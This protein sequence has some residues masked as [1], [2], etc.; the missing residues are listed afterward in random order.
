M[1]PNEKIGVT[2]NGQYMPEGDWQKEVEWIRVS[3]DT[4]NEKTFK[5]IKDGSLEKSL[6]TLKQLIQGSI[7]YAGAGF[8]YSRFN[9]DEVYRFL[10]MIYKDVYKDKGA[11]NGGNKNC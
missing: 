7:K 3:L 5:K 9:I 4:D 8:V 11:E 2:S 6:E 1:F 10:K